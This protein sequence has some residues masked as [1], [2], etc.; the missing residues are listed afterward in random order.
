[1]PPFPTYHFESPVVSLATSRKEGRRWRPCFEIKCHR[2]CVYET[3]WKQSWPLSYTFWN[4]S[5]SGQCS[6]FPRFFIQLQRKCAF[7]VPCMPDLHALSP[8]AISIPC[9]ILY[10]LLFPPYYNIKDCEL[11][12]LRLFHRFSTKCRSYFV[13]K[14]SWHYTVDYHRYLFWEQHSYLFH[15]RTI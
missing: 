7:S 14:Y 2:Q 3:Y 12:S 10:S 5:I 8:L 9:T 13:W 4:T 11:F 1:M 15:Q 6:S